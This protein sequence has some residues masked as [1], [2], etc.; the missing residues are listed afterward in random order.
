ME[1]LFA[2]STIHAPTL[3]PRT[4]GRQSTT[5]TWARAP[6]PLA[7]RKSAGGRRFAKVVRPS[8]APL[9]HGGT[10]RILRAR[11][12]EEHGILPAQTQFL[13]RGRAQVRH[14]GA[15]RISAAASR[16]SSWRRSRSRTTSPGTWGRIP[17]S[18]RRRTTWA[19]FS[20]ATA[21]HTAGGRSVGLLPAIFRRHPGDPRV[22]S[23]TAGSSRCSAIRWTWS[24]RCTRSCSTSP[25]RPKAI[26]RPRGGS[27]SAGPRDWTCRP[28]S[29]L[30]CWS[31]T[32]R[33]DSS[34]PRP[35][36]CSPPSP[37]NR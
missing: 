22:Q 2:V 30:R 33:W 15:L 4:R 20:G 37:A 14:H 7:S 18:R 6:A 1:G 9:R 23:R 31:S 26:S 32:A 3:D 21:A 8:V 11:T 17:G 24:T 36:G 35:S 19:L 34:A 29:A 12:T 13:P 16:T 28:G 25:K 5:A 27:R 10:Q